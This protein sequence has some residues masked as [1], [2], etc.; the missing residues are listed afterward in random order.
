[1]I[2]ISYFFSKALES[3]LNG[4]NKNISSKVTEAVQSAKAAFVSLDKYQQTLKDALDES[5]NEEVKEDQWKKVTNL[6]Q[7]QLKGVNEANEKFLLCSNSL[8]EVNDL[9]KDAK[10]NKLFKN[11]KVLSECQKVISS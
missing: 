9:I 3:K 11:L 7:E 8:A 2:S 6:F 5:Y 10:M 4:L 1:M